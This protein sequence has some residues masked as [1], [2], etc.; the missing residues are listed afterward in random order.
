M[1]HIAPPKP[2]KIAWP[3]HTQLPDTDGSIVENFQE[4]PQ[5]IVL[6]ESLW[7]VLQRLHPDG[8]FAVGQDSG[9]YWRNTD[10]PLRGC[11]APDW[12]YVPNVPPML[13]GQVRRSYVMWQELEHPRLVVEYVSGDGSEER[14]RTPGKGK[15]WIYERRI[16]AGYYAIYEVDLERVEVWRLAGGDYELVGANERGHYPIAPLGIELGIWEGPYKN[17]HLPWLRCWDSAGQLLPVDSERADEER[18]RAEEANRRAEEADRRAEKLAARLRELG[19]NPDE[20]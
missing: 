11:L 10:P 8:Q 16:C 12:F 4:H 15:F 17:F 18:R 1:N 13:E 3:D 7:P 14:D 6:T 5:G 20:L 9:I 19:G 2:E